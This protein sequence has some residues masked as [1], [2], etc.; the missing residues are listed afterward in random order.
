MFGGTKSNKIQSPIDWQAP[1]EAESGL[2]IGILT[3]IVNKEWNIN[4]NLLKLIKK[5]VLFSST[6]CLNWTLPIN[7]ALNFPLIE[8]V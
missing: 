1:N 2:V 7:E 3:K 5:Y 8:A 6:L 4:G